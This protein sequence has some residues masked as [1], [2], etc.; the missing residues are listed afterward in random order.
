VQCSR[1]RVLR[2]PL[3]ARSP[4]DAK[5]VQHRTN[6][7]RRSPKSLRRFIYRHRRDQVKKPSLLQLGP[8]AIG[9]LLF[10]AGTA[11]EAQTRF[12]RIPGNLYQSC[13]QPAAVRVTEI[14]A[15]DDSLFAFSDQVSRLFGPQEH[16]AFAH[17]FVFPHIADFRRPTL[18]ESLRPIPP[19]KL[20]A[21]EKASSQTEGRAKLSR[22]CTRTTV[23]KLNSTSVKAQRRHDLED[24]VKYFFLAENRAETA[25]GSAGMA[26]SVTFWGE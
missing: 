18:V 6:R 15:G 24:L 9:P 14:L 7:T 26:A 16:T 4:T 5:T 1:Q 23:A 19:K 2:E 10:E 3:P 20:C 11:Q 17:T 13:D 25:L 22:I 8:F 12:P 21:F